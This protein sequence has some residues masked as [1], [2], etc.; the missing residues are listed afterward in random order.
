MAQH[1]DARC[2]NCEACCYVESTKQIILAHSAPSGPGITD[3]ERQ[4]WNEALEKNPCKYPLV[5]VTY[6]HTTVKGRMLGKAVDEG[7]PGAMNYVSTIE[8][9]DRWIANRDVQDWTPDRCL[10]GINFKHLEAALASM[11]ATFYPGLINAIVVGAVTQKVF[12]P[13]GLVSLVTR[14]DA[15]YTAALNSGESL[16]TDPEGHRPHPA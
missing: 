4:L 13:G 14:L 11:P 2:G 10:D 12:Q 15:T 16:E 8:F 5:L 3:A 6:S 1:P 9:G 7:D